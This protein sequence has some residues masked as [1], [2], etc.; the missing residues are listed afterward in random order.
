M[1][2]LLVGYFLNSLIISEHA[3]KEACLGRLA[4]L[5]EKSAVVKCVEAPRATSGFVCSN[6][7]CYLGN[8]QQTLEVK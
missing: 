3:D 2:Y 5:Q 1:K 8:S 7:L 6:S 4:V